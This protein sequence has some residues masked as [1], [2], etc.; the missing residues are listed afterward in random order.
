MIFFMIK[1]YFNMFSKEVLDVI[2]GIL[3]S[4]FFKENSLK[5]VFFCG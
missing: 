4:Y 5:S 1:V 3:F 2:I